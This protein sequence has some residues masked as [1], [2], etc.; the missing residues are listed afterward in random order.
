MILSQVAR[1]PLL[2]L[3]ELEAT[4]LLDLREHEY[5]RQQS[6]HSIDAIGESKA[7]PCEHWEGLR[8]N[9]VGDPLRR[10]CDGKR[11]GANAIVEYFA[12]ITAVSKPNRNPPV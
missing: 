9:V 5:K 12:L 3:F 8:D 11:I 4:R 1:K 6:H 7:E 10:G 2:H